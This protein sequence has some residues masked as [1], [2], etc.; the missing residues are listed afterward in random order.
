MDKNSIAE[1]V[2]QDEDL[3]DKIDSQF[4]SQLNLIAGKHNCIIEDIDFKKRV[5][6]LAGPDDKQDECAR[7]LADILGRYLL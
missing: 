1:R 3:K 4:L 7:E 5:V 6:T 2:K